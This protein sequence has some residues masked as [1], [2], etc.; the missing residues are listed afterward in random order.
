[1]RYFDSYGFRPLAA[2]NF[3]VTT[4]ETPLVT[5]D[6][7]KQ[8]LAI[9]ETDFDTYLSTVVIPTATQLVSNII[10]EFPNDTI[11]AAYYNQFANEMVLPHVYVDSVSSVQYYDTDNVLQNLDGG[12]YLFDDTNQPPLVRITGAAPTLFPNRTSPVIV[13]YVAF[14]D[15]TRFNQ[16]AIVHATTM[17]A[18]DLWYNRSNTVDRGYSNARVTADRI[19]APL[20]KVVL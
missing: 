18:A 11:V 3:R 7:L 13:N 2:D 1:M 8:H 15:T 5:L 4:V 6:E 17:I 20:K 10:G 16:Q 19:L 12:L 9:Y 14:V